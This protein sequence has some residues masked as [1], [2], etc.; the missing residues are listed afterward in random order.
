M[1][2]QTL[3]LSDLKLANRLVMPPMATESTA[4]GKVTQK[5][6]DYY[7][8]RSGKIGL[9]ICE[10]AYVSPRGKASPGQLRLD[11]AADMQGLRA[12]TTAVHEQGVT[13]IIQQIN[14]AGP[15]T[16]VV[17]NPFV[18]DTMTAADIAAVKNE[19]VAAALRVKTAGFD[20]VEIHCAHGY[21]LNQ[22]YSPRKN[23]REDEYGG[24]VAGRLRLTCEIL[25]EVR[26]AVGAD[27][28]VAVRFG[29]VD[30]RENGSLLTEVA[31]AAKLLVQ[32]G[33]DLIDISGGLTGF[34]RRDCVTPGWF[35]AEAQAAKIG[36]GVSVL[37]TGGITSRETAEDLLAAGVCDLIGVGRPLLQNPGV[38]DAL[39]GNDSAE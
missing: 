39:L 15:Q 38:I 35:K 5:L 27:Y 31:P 13:K 22:F 18:V 12:L 33:A 14:H 20:G 19:F 21:L 36:G 24:D 11:E 29:A 7:V 30:Y 23:H 17:E 10:H 9:I 6:I 8:A 26:R 16:K 4:D 1:L 3:N 32:A 28:L 2:L 25:T 37:L 34:M